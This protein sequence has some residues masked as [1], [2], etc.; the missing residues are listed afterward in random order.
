MSALATAVGP[1]LF[2]ISSRAAGTAALLLSSASV[3]IGVAMGGRL[4]KGRGPDLRVTHEALSLATMAALAVHAL[5]LLGDGFLKL[6]VADISIPFASS[7]KT[8]WMS[9]GIVGGWLVFLLG[10]SYYARRRIGQARWRKLHTFTLLAW[11]LGVAHS[12]GEGTDA[13]QAWFLLATGI[14]ILPAGAL[15][16]SRLGGA[17]GRAGAAAAREAAR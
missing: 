8:L 7:Y 16:I 9:M 11:A 3:G 14:V 10:L 13:G 1:H 4:L 5:A 6:G 15:A 17:L 12:L 2:W